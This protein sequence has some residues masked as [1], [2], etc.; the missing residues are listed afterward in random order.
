MKP[1]HK[2]RQCHFGERNFSIFQGPWCDFF[3]KWKVTFFHRLFNYCLKG[4]PETAETVQI[5]IHLRLHSFL[6]YLFI[7]SSLIYLFVLCS[8]SQEQTIFCALV[9]KGNLC[10]Y[11]GSCVYKSQCI[12]KHIFRKKQGDFNTHKNTFDSYF[13]M[14]L[15]SAQHKGSI[16]SL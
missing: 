6:I 1:H 11:K 8:S 10:I 14:F 12:S 2:D 3:S 4:L 15:K 7:F 5:F 9:F 13:S 16:I